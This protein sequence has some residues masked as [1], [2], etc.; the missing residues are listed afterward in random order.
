MAT[1]SDLI[2]SREPLPPLTRLAAS[3]ILAMPVI[4]LY[5]QLFVFQQ[6]MFHLILIS[7]TALV[8]GAAMLTGLRWAP[9]LAPLFTP[10]MM[11]LEG[12]PHHALEAL[13]NPGGAEFIPVIFSICLT[14]IGAA[15]GIYAAAQNY[16][17]VGPRIP[18]WLMAGL[19]AVAALSA[20]GV[21][22]AS[23]PA[24]Q[25]GASVGVSAQLLAQAPVVETR[26]MA[27]V[28]P[29]IR[30][31]AGEVVTL[32]LLNSDKVGHSFDVDEL[33]L[34]VVM[35]AESEGAAVLKVTEPGTYTFYCAPHYHKASGKGMKGILVVTP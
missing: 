34:H 31:K 21:A 20:G 1:L 15:A 32:R 11:I 9:I 33:D 27:F 6:F 16:R 28:Q 8:F 24:P 5:L 29:E 13:A 19:V 18:R 23:I 22:V 30:V 14:S 26:Q 7:A 4:L 3:S 35:P 12:G 10:V 2:R 25:S 17:M